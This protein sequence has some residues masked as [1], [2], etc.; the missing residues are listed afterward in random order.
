MTGPVKSRAAEMSET[1]P[2]LHAAALLLS[3]DCSPFE[4]SLTPSS[5]SCLP[6]KPRVKHSKIAVAPSAQD[7]ASLFTLHLRQQIWNPGAF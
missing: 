5:A 1:F 7:E 6:P 4:T 3:S 2:T